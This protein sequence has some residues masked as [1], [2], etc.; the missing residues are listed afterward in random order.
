M[1]FISVLQWI[2]HWIKSL[3]NSLKKLIIRI[4]VVIKLN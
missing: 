1:I 2:F 4:I 3:Q